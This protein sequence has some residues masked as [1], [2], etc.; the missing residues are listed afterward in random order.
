MSGDLQYPA[1]YYNENVEEW[2]SF[3]PEQD[4]YEDEIVDYDDSGEWYNNIYESEADV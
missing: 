2:T 3:V 1:Y 4:Y